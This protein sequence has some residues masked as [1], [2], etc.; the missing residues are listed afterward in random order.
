MSF[1]SAKKTFLHVH[2]VSVSHLVK[3][4][5]M[6]FLRLA[7]VS[8]EDRRP[9]REGDEQHAGRSRWQTDLGAR[10]RAVQIGALRR[11]KP[12]RIFPHIHRAYIILPEVWKPRCRITSSVV[13]QNKQ[14][15]TGN[16][17]GLG[18]AYMSFVRANMDQIAKKITDDLWVLSA[19][20]VNPTSILVSA[21][22]PSLPEC[23]TLS[24]LVHRTSPSAV[25]VAHR[26][27]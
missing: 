9:N 3:A 10:K 24:A 2:N 5:F 27:A 20:E 21:L 25:H 17:T 13:F 18:K 1:H 14:G 12:H 16:G 22:N 19:M 7:Q 6:S 15:M 23:V 4:N 26:S 11:G 8:H